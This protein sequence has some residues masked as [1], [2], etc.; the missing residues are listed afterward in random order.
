MNRRFNRFNDPNSYQ[1]VKADAQGG[2]PY[3]KVRDPHGEYVKCVDG[4]DWGHTDVTVAA[5]VR[6]Q[7]NSLQ[8]ELEANAE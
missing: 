4:S 8:D 2:R 7:Y 5:R 6:D 3:Y 1:V